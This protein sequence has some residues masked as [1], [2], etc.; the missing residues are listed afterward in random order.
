MRKI[1]VAYFV[2][3]WPPYHDGGDSIFARDL[4]TDIKSKLNEY[5]VFT[6]HP[7][8][9]KH[10]YYT[11]DKFN[12]KI[13]FL[14]DDWKSVL[15]K[16]IIKF[17]PDIIHSFQIHNYQIV[18]YLSLI[19]K[20]RPKIIFHMQICFHRYKEL[21]KPD[22]N[23]YL[24]QKNERSLIKI[25]DIVIC[26]SKE[27]KYN[28][29]RLLK[30]KE[31]VVVP[32]GINYKIKNLN[33]KINKIN[34]K[35]RIVFAG[36]ID[37]PMKGID[38]IY[39]A[40]NNLDYKKMKSLKFVFIGTKDT[41]FMNKLDFS[42]RVKYSVIPW[43]NNQNKFYEELSKNDVLLMPSLYEP[44]GILCIEGMS[45]GLI[46]IV[47]RTGGLKEIVRHSDGGYLLPNPNKLNSNKITSSL[48]NAIDSLLSLDKKSLIFIKKKSQKRARMYSIKKSAKEIIRIYSKLLR[49]KN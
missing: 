16:L 43:I 1:K 12:N 31:I 20:P 41:S 32:N 13:V 19:I 37:D 18:K 34:D 5:Y 44:F 8:N 10:T 29:N 48:L 17:K 42:K 14:G 47:T 49:G 30:P 27:E 22:Y 46:P 24:Y 2:D 21:F 7:K 4:I 23:S 39:N 11:K 9:I 28:V 35:L 26:P 40:I 15:S 45:I 6:K 33:F 25:S 3:W 36:R 38:I